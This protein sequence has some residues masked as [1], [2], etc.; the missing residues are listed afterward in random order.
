MTKD[1]NFPYGYV[2]CEKCG[3]KAAMQWIACGWC[4]EVTCDCK[5]HYL[6]QKEYDSK[7]KGSA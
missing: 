7:Q 5:A 6:T 2:V 1:P 3:A 4:V